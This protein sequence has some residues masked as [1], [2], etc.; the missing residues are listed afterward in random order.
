MLEQLFTAPWA[1]P[2]LR[3]SPF[4]PWLEAFDDWLI[5]R[6][7]P[8]GSR[9]S[10]VVIAADLGRWMDDQGHAVSEL[11]EAIIANYVEQRVTQ[12]DR[13]RVAV[14]HLLASLRAA[15]VVSVPP[16]VEDHSPVAELCRRYATHLGKAQGAAAGTIEGYVAVV[17]S[18]LGRRFETQLL[19]PT[20]LTAEDVGQFLVARAHELSLARIDYLACA[21]RSFL[22]YLFACGETTSDLS[23]A[24]PGAQRRH[25]PVVSRSLEPA[26]VERLIESADPNTVGGSRDR[27]MLLLIARLGLRAGEVAALEIDDIRW[28]SG[29]LVVRGKGNVVDRLPLLR[30][31]GEALAHY[32]VHRRPR[33]TTR[34]VFLRLCSPIR[35]VAGR[36][37]VSSMV[38]ARLRRLGLHPSRQGAH[39]LRHSLGTN[40]IR[41]GATLAE[42]GEVLRH[43]SPGSTQI[44]AKVDVDALRTL[45]RAWPCVGGGR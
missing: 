13:R 15:D 42:I 25:P 38:R 5:A 8:P 20:A 45:A 2:R 34:R 9:R 27:A 12:P 24:A 19:D 22:R 16:V 40:M 14:T 32:L 10:Y 43:H 33:H 18:F 35:E 29:E 3:G 7:Y 44:Y 4:G 30:D 17:R 11:C 37:A 41:S 28:R 31:V 26:D 1:A 6:G 36:G 21:L 39:I 23:L